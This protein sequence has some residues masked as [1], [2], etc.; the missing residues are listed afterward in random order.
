MMVVSGLR[1]SRNHVPAA[2]WLEVNR[3]RT[4]FKLC[5]I[6]HLTMYKTRDVTLPNTESFEVTAREPRF[7]PYCLTALLPYLP[8]HRHIQT[9]TSKATN[10]QSIRHRTTQR[11]IERPANEL[12]NTERRAHTSQIRTH[13]VTRA[14]LSVPQCPVLRGLPV[15]ARAHGPRLSRRDISRL[16]R[17]EP[18]VALR[19]GEAPFDKT[20]EL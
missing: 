15:H 2:P 4:I 16:C 17:G 8:L 7:L 6:Q 18:L 3:A 19:C 20:A 12:L 13:N 9:L 14:R 1:D 11:D 10:R 5:Y